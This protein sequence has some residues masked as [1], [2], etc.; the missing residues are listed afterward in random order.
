[1]W[2]SQKSNIDFVQFAKLT[3]KNELCYPDFGVESKFFVNNR[4]KT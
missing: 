4:M 3:I 2:T 1:M